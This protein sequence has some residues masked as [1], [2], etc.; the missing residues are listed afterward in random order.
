[1]RNQ[2]LEI[3]AMQAIGMENVEWF[4]TFP[5]SENVSAS[6]ANARVLVVDDDPVFCKV[7]Q[8]VA[9]KHKVDITACSSLREVL[10][11][12]GDANFDLA[13]LD[14]YFGDM[15]AIQIAYLLKTNAPQ[16]FVSAYNIKE[17]ALPKRRRVKGFAKKSDGADRILSRA[18]AACGVSFGLRTTEMGPLQIFPNLNAQKDTGQSE[19]SGFPLWLRIATFGIVVSFLLL[20]S[21]AMMGHHSFQSEPNLI[22]PHDDLQAPRPLKW[23]RAPFHNT[24]PIV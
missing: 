18:L 15:T 7:M 16:F 21:T 4:G 23:D 3:P 11:L 17:S 6:H 8:K 10:E 2:L 20:V 12:P 22:L 19:E 1:M 5:L 13:I 24:V 9:R 14:Y